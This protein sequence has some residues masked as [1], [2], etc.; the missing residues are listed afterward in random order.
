MSGFCS[1]CGHLVS[2]H[3]ASDRHQ[4]IRQSRD[5]K[6]GEMRMRVYQTVPCERCTGGV[7]RNDWRPGDHQNWQPE[8]KI[9]NYSITY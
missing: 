4:E 2:R 6:T 9:T 7:C 8:Q 5:G 1:F 3:V